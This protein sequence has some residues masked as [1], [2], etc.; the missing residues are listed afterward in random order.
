MLQ[1]DGEN[2][3]MEQASTHCFLNGGPDLEIEIKAC[4]RKTS[5][6]ESYILPK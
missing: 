5:W 6:Y 2:I 4:R 1:L 3:S